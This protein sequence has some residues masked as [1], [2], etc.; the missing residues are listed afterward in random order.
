MKR[1]GRNA[2]RPHPPHDWFDAIAITRPHTVWAYPR[3]NAAKLA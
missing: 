2:S 3:C 1:G